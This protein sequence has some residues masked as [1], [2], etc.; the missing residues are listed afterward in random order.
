MQNRNTE[1][2]VKKYKGCSWVKRA[3]GRHKFRVSEVITES[4][5]EQREHAVWSDSNT[6]IRLRGKLYA[7]LA[8]QEG[9]RH[10]FA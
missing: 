3:G 2:E 6:H 9:N 5:G 8:S 7:I 1:V 4:T 10:I